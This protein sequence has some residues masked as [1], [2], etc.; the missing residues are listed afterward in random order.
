MTAI[1][2]TLTNSK[3]PDTFVPGEWLGSVVAFEPTVQ[4]NSKQQQIG[5]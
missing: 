1:L 4:C 3:A 2:L 5:A